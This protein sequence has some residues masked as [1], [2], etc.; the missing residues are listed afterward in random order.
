MPTNILY[1][2]ADWLLSLMTEQQLQQAYIDFQQFKDDFILRD[3]E[4]INDLIKN[5]INK[6][7]ENKNV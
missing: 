6:L 5:K 2:T 1:G 4:K 3:F 7:K